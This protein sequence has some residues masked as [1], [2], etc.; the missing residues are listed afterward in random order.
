M[1]TKLAPFVE[2]LT[3]ALMADG[4]RPGMNGVRRGRCMHS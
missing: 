1:P 3:Q 4:H 2:A